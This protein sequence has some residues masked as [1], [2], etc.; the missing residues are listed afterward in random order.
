MI[1]VPLGGISERCD[2]TIELAS[3]GVRETE[4]D[5]S[6]RTGIEAQECLDR[7]G[8]QNARSA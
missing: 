6:R 3:A 4:G 5:L 2:R 1:G 8:V 7:L